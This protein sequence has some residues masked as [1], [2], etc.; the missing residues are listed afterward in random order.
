MLPVIRAHQGLSRLRCKTLC[1][2]LY[3]TLGEFCAIQAQAVAK[4][5][6]FDAK[7]NTA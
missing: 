4:I 3:D 7:I 2:V 1:D 6:I 5:F